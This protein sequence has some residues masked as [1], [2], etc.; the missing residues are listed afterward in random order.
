[1]NTGH[2]N[3]NDENKDTHA[4]GEK[5]EET[6]FKKTSGKYYDRITNYLMLYFHT[7]LLYFNILSFLHFHLKYHMKLV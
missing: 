2:T 5:D 6:R 1:M 3:D 7:Y 4:H